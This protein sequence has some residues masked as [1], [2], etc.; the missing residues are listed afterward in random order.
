[1]T[2]DFT[3]VSV[4]VTQ[5]VNATMPA[6][7]SIQPALGSTS[8]FLEGALHEYSIKFDHNPN[9]KTPP[10]LQIFITGTSKPRIGTIQ[11]KGATKQRCLIATPGTAVDNTFQPAFTKQEVILAGGKCKATLLLDAGGHMADFDGLP[12]PIPPYTGP[13]FSGSGAVNIIVIENETP[14]Q[15]PLQNNTSPHG[16]T[17]GD[18]TTTCYGP[19]RPSVPKC[20][21]TAQPCP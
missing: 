16:I 10:P 15:K 5:A 4:S 8:N 17:F 13:C 6:S 21:C 20:V 14:T 3:E 2:V 19:P 11:L 7:I 18:G 12:T 1:M 9:T